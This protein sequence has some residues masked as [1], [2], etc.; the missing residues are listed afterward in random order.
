M[1]ELIGNGVSSCLDGALL[2]WTR[3]ELQKVGSGDMFDKVFGLEKP[4]SLP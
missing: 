2:P 4:P 3:G 1:L